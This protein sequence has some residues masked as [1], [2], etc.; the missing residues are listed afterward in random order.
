VPKSDIITVTEWQTKNKQTNKQKRRKKKKRKEKKNPRRN[1]FFILK[2]IWTKIRS[3]HFHL[4]KS[5]GKEIIQY[6]ILFNIPVLG[7]G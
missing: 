2:Y 3:F 1:K 6:Y 5:G 7:L 4:G